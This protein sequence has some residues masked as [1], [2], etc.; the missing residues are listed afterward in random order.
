MGGIDP[1]TYARIGEIVGLLIAGASASILMYLKGPRKSHTTTSATNPMI[2]GIGM[3]LMDKHDVERGLNA[4]ES[5]AKDMR[6][7]ATSLEEIADRK[8]ADIAD[9]LDDIKD[10]LKNRK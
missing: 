2:A 10:T 6:V 5:I 9:A 3:G 8:Q 1:D 4:W 7:V